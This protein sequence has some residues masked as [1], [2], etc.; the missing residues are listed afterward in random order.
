[1]KLRYTKAW[2]VNLNQRAPREK[3]QSLSSLPSKLWEVISVE[4]IP[5]YQLLPSLLEKINKQHLQV[6]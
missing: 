4:L 6:Q 2:K 5:Y 1:M 3:E